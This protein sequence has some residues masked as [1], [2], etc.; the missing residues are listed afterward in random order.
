MQLVHTSNNKPLM[1]LDCNSNS[2]GVVAL[3][4]MCSEPTH[5]RN[6]HPSI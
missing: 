5:R 3:G 1:Q 4:L 6:T 2:E